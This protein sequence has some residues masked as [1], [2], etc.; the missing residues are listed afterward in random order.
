VN[1]LSGRVRWGIERFVFELHS[2]DDRLLCTSER[3]FHCWP[4]RTDGPPTASWMLAADGDGYTIE[5]GIEIPDGRRIDRVRSAGA[6]T[7]AI[8]VG[9]V[10]KILES[11][12]GVLCVHGALVSR[13]NGGVVIVGP[14]GA[15]KST[16]ACALWNDGWSLLCDDVSM[17]AGED[18]LPTPRRVS[19]RRN[20]LDLVDSPLL[21]HARATPGFVET[22]AGCVFQP[23]QVDDTRTDRARLAA[24]VFLARRGVVDRSVSRIPPAHA[25]LALLPYTNL[26]RRTS[27]GEALPAVSRLASEVP[28]FDVA[29]T[30]LAA[31]IETVAQIAGQA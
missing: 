2:T 20:G 11:P 25:A 30:S 4:A 8:E 16:L 21:R 9:A 23:R 1:A 14:R 19:L 5:P 24:I 15:G 6:A 29:R 31:M 3:I 18:A 17:I 27:V 10:Q 22:S 7:M 28:A 26:A 13:G 12:R